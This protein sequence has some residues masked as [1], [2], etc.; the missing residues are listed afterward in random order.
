MEAIGKLIDKIEEIVP[1]LHYEDTEL[2]FENQFE[3][4]EEI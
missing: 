2:D 3:Q 1:E 4:G